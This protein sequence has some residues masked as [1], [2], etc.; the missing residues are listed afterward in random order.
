[1]TSVLVRLVRLA[2]RSSI[3][4]SCSETLTCSC[5]SFILC[6][7]VLHYIVVDKVIN[8][9]KNLVAE[10]TTLNLD[11]QIYAVLLHCS[12]VLPGSR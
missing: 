6:T 12:R 1:M 8:H 10:R 5:F 4:I 7:D 11:N 9:S 3:S 2:Y